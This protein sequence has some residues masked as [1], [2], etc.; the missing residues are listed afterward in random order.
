MREEVFRSLVNDGGRFAA[1]V[2]QYP[3]LAEQVAASIDVL[4]RV[5]GSGEYHVIWLLV[6]MPRTAS[7]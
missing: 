7:T 1:W 6:V 5:R 3:L 4:Q 2:S